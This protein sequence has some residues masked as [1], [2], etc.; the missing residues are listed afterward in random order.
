MSGRVSLKRDYENN[1]QLAQQLQPKKGRPGSKI[2]IIFFGTLAIYSGFHMGHCM[3]QFSTFFE[4]FMRGKFGQSIKEREFDGIQ[5]LMNTIF[6]LGL[7]FFAL[8][9]AKLIETRSLKKLN[10][11]SILIYIIFSLLQIPL[12]LEGVYAMRFL[13][14]VCVAS[15]FALGPVLVNNCLPLEYLGPIGSLFSFFI[16]LGLIVGSSVSSEISEWYWYIFLCISLPVEVFRFVM[17]S[18]VVPYES[19]YYVYFDIERSAKKKQEESQA[20]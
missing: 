10:L 19:P 17:L 20:K 16:V 12:P 1:S 2:K 11:V 4:Y 18:L 3:S 15:M 8:T 13:L 7:L 9:S 5:S 6:V 14:G